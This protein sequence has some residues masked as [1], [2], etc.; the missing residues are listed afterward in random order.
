MDLTRHCLLAVKRQLLDMQVRLYF[1]HTKTLYRDSGPQESLEL[2][3]GS[4]DDALEAGVQVSS[5]TASLN[6]IW[7]PR[8]CR[9]RSR[10]ARHVIGFSTDMRTSAGHACAQEDAIVSRV[11]RRLLHLM[12]L[13]VEQAGDLKVL[14]Y[15]R[16]QKFDAHLDWFS[17]EH[18]LEHPKRRQTLANVIIYLCAP[19]CS[20]QEGLRR[21]HSACCSQGDGSWV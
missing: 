18:L 2:P 6:R 5:T 3:K 9:K 12:G 8:T 13:P 1:D 20:S 10:E 21:P 16:G 4:T 7:S 14:R 15:E 17:K 19:P 11:E